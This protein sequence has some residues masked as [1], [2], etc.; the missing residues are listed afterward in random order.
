MLKL[1]AFEE[2]TYFLEQLNTGAEVLLIPNATYELLGRYQALLQQ[3]GYIQ[4]EEYRTEQCYFAAFKKAGDAV[5]INFFDG[6]KELQLVSEQNTAYFCYTDA[7]GKGITTSQLTQVRLTDY[8]LSYVIRLEDGRFLVIDGGNRVEAEADA[9]YDCLAEQSASEIPVIAAWIMTHPHSDHFYCYFPFME[10][11]GDKVKIE[12]FLFSFPEAHDYAHYPKLERECS[13]FQGCTD[14][15]VIQRF[16]DAVQELGIPVYVPHTG[17]RYR[18][19]NALLRFLGTMDDTIHCSNN[20][21]AS[22]LIF[23]MEI[24]G[25]KILWGADGSFGD[26]RL[27]SRYGS[28]LSADIL[29]VPHHGFGCGPQDA[30]IECYQLIAPRVC[31]LPASHKEAFTSF[32]THCKSTNYLMT[33]Q[34]V[35]EFITGKETRILQLPYE[36]SPAG[37]TELRQQYLEGR[38]NCGARTWIFTELNTG[39]KTDFV[40]SVLNT[41]YLDAALSVELY[42]EGMQKRIVHISSKGPRLGVFR[43]NCAVHADEDVTIFDDPAFLES[44]GI[45]VDTPFAVRF[46]SSIP[47]V[48]SHPEHRPAYRSCVV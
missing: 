9:L 40:F 38:D 20:I 37:A 7:D 45:P 41:T 28:E 4:K 14:G 3:A 25:Q 31:L 21:N 22:S 2:E 47:V 29:Q 36:P 5:F 27:A 19:G 43:I 48:I 42:F 13:R 46:I 11:Y 12:K 44:R 16:T 33:R 24:E 17:Q 32:A 35:E 26:A 18:I 39:I 1:P 23:S 34:N 10:R 6:A 30:T 15:D 8:G